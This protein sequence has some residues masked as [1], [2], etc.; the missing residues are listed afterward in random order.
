MM[1]RNNFMKWENPGV[2][3]ITGSS[4]G[5]GKEFACQLAKQGFNLILVARREQKLKEIARE[6]EEKY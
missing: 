5:I 2:A 4:S 3:L 1:N 6:L